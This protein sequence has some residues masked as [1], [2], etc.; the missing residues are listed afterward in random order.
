MAVKQNNAEANDAQA[1]GSSNAGQGSG[2]Q[3]N[4]KPS[5]N[6][7]NVSDEGGGGQEQ[8]DAAGLG[9]NSEAGGDQV[10]S[11]MTSATA[12]GGIKH[13]IQDLLGIIQ[14]IEQHDQPQSFGSPGMLRVYEHVICSLSRTEVRNTAE[15]LKRFKEDI[16]KVGAFLAKPNEKRY[17][18]FYLRIVYE[19]ITQASFEPPTCAVAIVFQLFNPN[20]IIEAVQSLLEQNVLDSSIRKTVNLLCEWV[21]VCNFC[22]NLNLWVMA[23]LTGLREQEKYLLLDNIALDNIEKL[24]ML[25]ILPALR[26]KV[27][28]IVFHM[29]ST[30]Y[31][32]PE[33][34]HKIL[35]KIP[36]VIR[37]LKQQS[38][39][40]DEFGNESR[41]YMQ[42]LVDLTN[43]LMLRFN[44]N[45][46]LYAPVKAALHMYEPSYNYVALA[47][48]M[49]ENALPVGRRNARVGL[50]N[51]GNTCYM[52]SVLQVL[53]M[54]NDF[55]RQ[56]LLIESTSPLLLKVQQQIAL[57]H[58]SMRYELTPSRVLSAT[59]PPGFTPGLQQDSSEFLGY[60]LDLLHEHEINNQ[61]HKRNGA[62]QQLES[63][64]ASQAEPVTQTGPIL[65]DEIAASGVIPYN[66]MDSE[67]SAAHSN[68]NSGN[69]NNT[70]NSSSATTTCSGSSVVGGGSK[71]NNALTPTKGTTNHND[72]E[73]VPKKPP[74]TIDKTFT[75]KLA[76]TYRCLKCSWKS[77]NEDSFRELQLSFPDDK[78]DCGATN[79]SV[80]DL[81]EYYCSPEKMDGEN[82]YYCPRCQS[83]CDAERRIGVTQ[84]PRN[85]ILTLKQFKYD[86]KYHF[87]T[88]LMHKV[89]HDESVTVKVCAND[90]LQ[91]LST[92]HYDLY[93]GVVHSGFSMDSGHYFTFAADQSKNW[94]KFND[95]LVTISQPEEM[96]NL[97]SPNTPY[98][99]FYQMCGR[100]NEMSTTG[101]AHT[102]V[103]VQMPQPLTLEE[104]PRT[105]RDFVQQDNRVYTEELK[106]QRFKHNTKRGNERNGYDEDHS[107]PPSGGCG[108][109]GLGINVNRFVY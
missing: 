61:H 43:A 38:N 57:M 6:T 18:I 69:S 53:A 87:R 73:L 97:T 24:F 7:S 66:S 32:T 44:D 106:L 21:R 39:S 102:M 45:D 36:G 35:P 11:Q 9:N 30:I 104:L 3:P 52:N 89:F 94:Y 49:H 62:A 83:L 60:L 48:A 71:V 76:T 26:P 80:Q 59:R 79:Y 92:V 16:A 28:P 51:L 88:K 1:T 67:I 101:S 75:G 27:A 74:S 34:F 4:V 107:P 108:G 64:D 65:D 82:K 70:N 17:L 98:I 46:D 63:G 50:V 47:R 8:A 105:L 40:M 29:L 13:D 96:H 15:D 41:A 42:K 56:I 31:Q 33:I 68:K 90:T 103:T 20:S 37:Y 86:Q 22:Q 100:S 2:S 14:T 19:L 25:M 109:N 81:I 78:E 5:I 77:C 84:A 23:L 85:L 10:D 55:S 99:L 93:A 95:S 58:H 91:E 54:T 12:N 72:K